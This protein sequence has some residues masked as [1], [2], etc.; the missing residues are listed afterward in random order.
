M[1]LSMAWNGSFSDFP[2]F[3]TLN[4]SMCKTDK[5]VNELCKLVI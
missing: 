1:S 3:E 2:I 4:F 5:V